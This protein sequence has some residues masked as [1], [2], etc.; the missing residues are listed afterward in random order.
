MRLHFE[1]LLSMERRVG[2]WSCFPSR[3]RLLLLFVLTVGRALAEASAAAFPTSSA[4]PSASSLPSGSAPP[5]PSASRSAPPFSCLR[6]VGGCG[7]ATLSLSSPQTADGST[8]SP[9]G[10]SGALTTAVASYPAL[11]AQ[12]SVALSPPPAPGETVS[13][14]CA[15]A[16]EGLFSVAAV[17]PAPTCGAACVTLDAVGPQLASFTLASAGVRGRG[18]AGTLTCVVAS[19]FSPP[20]P[21]ESGNGNPPLPVYAPVVALSARAAALPGA[22]PFLGAILS[23]GAAAQRGTFT[24][25]AGGGL[26]ALFFLGDPVNCTVVPSD[27]GRM[28]ASAPPP[29]SYDRLC[30]AGVAAA[31]ALAAAAAGSPAPPS[32][33]FALTRATHLLLAAP[34]GGPPLPPGLVAALGGVPCATNWVAP[35]GA[36]A[37]ITTPRVEDL[38]SASRALTGDCGLVPLVLAGAPGWG[39]IAADVAWGT[40]ASALLPPLQLPAAY[41]PLLPGAD[42]SALLA[43]SGSRAGWGGEGGGSLAGS[44]AALAG[45]G[46]GGAAAAAAGAPLAVGIRALLPC[47]AGVFAA[48][49]ECAASA[50]AGA[51]PPGPCAWGA[52][53]ACVPCPPGAACP[54]GFT[55][56]PLPGFWA[57]QP[58]SPPAQLIRCPEPAATLR[59]PGWRNLTAGAGAARVFGCGAG[60]AGVACAACASGFFPSAGA[61]APC[62]AASQSGALAVASPFLIFVGVVGALGA[63][64]TLFAVGGLGLQWGAALAEAGALAAFFVAAAQPAAAAF[65]VTQAL[66]PPSVAPLYTVFSALQLAGFPTPPSCTAAPPFLAT[67][68][69]AGVVGGAVLAGGAALLLSVRAKRRGAR[70]AVGAPRLLGAAAGAL[71]LSFG[72]LVGAVTP[73]LVC[74]PPA[75]MGVRAYLSL[76]NDGSALDAALGDGASTLSAALALSGAAGASRAELQR[77]AADHAFAAAR[78][79]APALNASLAVS[80]LASEPF[81]VCR[82]GEHGGAFLAAA[83]TAAALGGF[84]ALGA[85]VAWRRGSRAAPP[86]A[87]APA[88]APAADS[89]TGGGASPP[90]SAPAP[91]PPPPPPAAIAAAALLA[92]LTPADVRPAAAWLPPA[93][94][95]LTAATSAF[96]SASAAERELRSFCAMQGA[97]A[98]LALLLAAA[99]LRAAPYESRAA[100]KGAATAALLLLYVAASVASVVLFLGGSGAVALSVP[101]ALAAACAPLALAYPLPPLLVFAWWRAAR[102]AALRKRAPAAGGPARAPHS[103]HHP[104]FPLAAAAGAPAPPSGRP[105]PL[106]PPRRWHR[107]RHPDGDVSFVEAHSGERAWVVPDGDE[108]EGAGVWH[109]ERVARGGAMR[110]ACAATGATAARDA[111]LPPGAITADG[112]WRWGGAAWTR[113]RT[114]ETLARGAPL[115]AEW[116]EEERG[117][118]AAAA[119][120]ARAVVR[121]AALRAGAESFPLARRGGWGGIAAAERAA[122]AAAAARE[123]AAARRWRPSNALYSA[124]LHGAA[125]A[126]AAGRGGG[127]AGGEEGGAAAAHAGA[128]PSLMG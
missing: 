84:A 58:S 10:I 63:V 66:A 115:R 92:A 25:V 24:S 3:S 64:L 37:S 89:G 51:A 36:A 59:C 79:L 114:G 13:I 62:P 104:L 100:W 34:K 128:P 102:G 95:L 38:C 91:P 123:A 85:C 118:P 28:N 19:A 73:A 40:N 30:T 126:A 49:Q 48:P 107:V 11:R 75:P 6:R 65:R 22:W 54:G 121:E 124:A 70:D 27:A 116:E 78:G 9:L 45:S 77:A 81:R 110:W 43:A 119:A 53:D 68:V 109:L 18:D 17:A 1:T 52:G 105:P 96:A 46:W 8:A 29:W 14:T 44:L 117:D 87:P 71:G 5:T 60:Y 67:W 99:L 47:D 15:G 98:A 86:P 90:P 101:A 50:A 2:W 4:P 93:Q 39:N 111:E 113:V 57:P 42:F 61:C 97:G 80:V 55:L 103:T 26:G 106:A 72:T 82:E 23:E 12:F 125:A 41:P 56:L 83:A 21:Q 16:P 33:F 32:L 7:S 35:D 120:A 74:A 112:E 76:L 88:P 122:A 108:E 127:G 20:R 31:S 69:A 94:L